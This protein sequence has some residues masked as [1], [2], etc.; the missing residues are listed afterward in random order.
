MGELKLLDCTLRDGGYV[1]DW[2]FGHNNLISIYE[3]LIDSNVD[4]IELGFLDDRREFDIDRSIMPDTDC[5]E[6]IYGTVDKKGKIVFGMIDYGT[7]SIDHIKPASESYIDGI[8]VIYKKHLRVEALDFCRQLKELGYIVYSQLVSVTSYTDDEMLDL[9]R[10]ANEAKPDAV[11]MVDT[12]GLMHQNNLMHFIDLLDKGL[13][14]DI[15]LGYHGH[16]NFQMGYANCIAMLAYETDRTMLVDGT[17][18]GMGKSAGNAPLE[19]IAMH[20]NQKYGKNYKISQMLEAIDA[21]IMNFYQPST[22]GYN[23]FFYLAASNDCHPNYVADLMNKKTLSIKSINE[24]LSRLEGEK[25]LLYDKKYMEDLY[26][27]YQSRDIDDSDA[28][29]RL[30]ARFDS[31]STDIF[32]YEGDHEHKVDGINIQKN[33]LVIGPGSS[34]STEREK[35]D[36]F[37]EKTREADGDENL[38]IIAINYIPEEIPIDMIFISNSKRYLQMSSALARLIS[39]GENDSKTVYDENGMPVESEGSDRVQIIATSNVTSK[40]L[41]FDYTLN[42]SSLIDEEADIIDNSFIMLLKAL[43]KAGVKQVNVAGFD[44][45]SDDKLNFINPDMEYTFIKDRTAELNQ[46]AKDKLAELSK[47][48]EV[49]FVTTSLYT[50]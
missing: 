12:Y 4:Y 19:L 41:D 11:S 3:R 32:E 33:I 23:L 50:M 18:Y 30:S 46:Y 35:L 5:M 1:N 24:L 37:I 48:I 17:L 39:T 7:C 42:Y 43:V 8:R 13:D 38:E 21:N 9:I 15:A 34:V 49:N 25:K 26:L 14:P 36:A 28:I 6:K 22:W 16:N 20:M 31:L 44:G 47:D 10:L 40:R 29:K 45:Y 27:E 2:K